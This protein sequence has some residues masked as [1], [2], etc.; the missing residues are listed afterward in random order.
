MR[1]K[2]EYVIDQLRPKVGFTQHGMKEIM[3]K[4]LHEYVNIGDAMAMP[5]TW[6][7]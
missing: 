2:L 4:V 6:R 1:P 7:K 5:L 3:L